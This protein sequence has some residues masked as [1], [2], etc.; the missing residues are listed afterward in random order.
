M[1]AA[2]RSEIANLIVAYNGGPASQSALDHAIALA[3]RHGAH[4]TGLLAH[5]SSRISRNIPNWFEESLRDKIMSVLS[6]RAIEIREAFYDRVGDALPLPRLHWRR[7][8]PP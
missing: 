5:G 3:V 7:A 8:M 4:L 6:R 1:T 2:P